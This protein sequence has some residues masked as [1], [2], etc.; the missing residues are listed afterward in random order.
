MEILRGGWRGENS[1]PEHYPVSW[2]GNS[3]GGPSEAPVNQTLD[4]HE[5]KPEVKLRTAL[6]HVIMFKLILALL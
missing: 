4:H 5:Q 1:A 3:V 6:K 2:R